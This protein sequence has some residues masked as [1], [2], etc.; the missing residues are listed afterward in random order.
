MQLGVYAFAMT[1]ITVQQDNPCG[2]VLNGDASSRKA[3]VAVEVAKLGDR[4]ISMAAV[5]R[6]SGLAPESI[7]PLRTALKTGETAIVRANAA[8][9]L[10]RIGPKP[11]EIGEAV[12]DL[13]AALKDED[14]LVRRQAAGAL[15]RLGSRAKSA[16]PALESAL[17]DTDLGVRQLATFGIERI[18]ESIKRESK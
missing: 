8:D 7:P 18:N 14:V 10:G 15:S 5:Q 1:V 9:A 6:L 13:I 12:P 16:L 2:A 4:S 11:P 17:Q 3:C